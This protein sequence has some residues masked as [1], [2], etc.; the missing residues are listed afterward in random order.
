MH[1][2]FSTNL[3]AKSWHAMSLTTGA[4]VCGLIMTATTAAQDLDKYLPKKGLD[5]RMHADD[6]RGGFG[7]SSRIRRHSDC[8]D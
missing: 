6:G 2:R 3:P 8:G 1:D 7:V 4:L 5:L